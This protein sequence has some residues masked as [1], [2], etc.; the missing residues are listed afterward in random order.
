METFPEF[1]SRAP[2][3]THRGS[4]VS[5][6]RSRLGTGVWPVGTLSFRHSTGG[7][8]E[9]PSEN[10]MKHCDLWFFEWENPSLLNTFDRYNQL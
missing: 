8:G 10:P 6:A 2:Q 1:T 7:N 9:I 5:A 4:S 3:Q